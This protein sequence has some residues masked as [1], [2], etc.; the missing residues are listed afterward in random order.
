[1]YNLLWQRWDAEEGLA[2]PG[3]FPVGQDLLAPEA[4]PFLD[5]LQGTAFQAP[6]QDCAM[7]GN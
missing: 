5:E 2:F 1:M 6:S 7:Y 4:G 3:T